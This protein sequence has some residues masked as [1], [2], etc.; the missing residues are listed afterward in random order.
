MASTVSIR[1]DPGSG[2]EVAG[3]KNS[4]YKND[5]GSVIM[6]QLIAG[7]NN[8]YKNYLGSVIKLKLATRTISI[9]IIWV[10]S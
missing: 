6:L 10:Q 1:A 7:F 3:N 9:R 5:L 8:L 4:L 2:K